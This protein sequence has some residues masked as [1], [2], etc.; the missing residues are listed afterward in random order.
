[1]TKTSKPHGKMTAQI[2]KQVKQKRRQKLEQEIFRKDK[3]IR[4]QREAELMQAC[5]D[6]RLLLDKMRVVKFP[7][8][9]CINLGIFARNNLGPLWK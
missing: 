6:L 7:D 2:A 1:M 8:S 3:A 4:K 9:I 5:L